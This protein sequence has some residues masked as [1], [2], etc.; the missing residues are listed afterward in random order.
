MEREDKLIVGSILPGLG[1]FL[2]MIRRITGTP[3]TTRWCGS[4]GRG[5]CGHVTFCGLSGHIPSH[6][7]TDKGCR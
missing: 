4:C 1:E 2:P 6:L 7:R 5:I 3:V